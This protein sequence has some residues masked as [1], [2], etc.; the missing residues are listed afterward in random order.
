MQEIFLDIRAG[1]RN[2]SP[3]LMEWIRHGYASAGE[4]RQSG[5]ERLRLHGKSAEE[6]YNLLET[7]ILEESLYEIWHTEGSS[8]RKFLEPDEYRLFQKQVKEAFKKHEA[9]LRDVIREEIKPMLAENYNVNVNGY[10]RFSAAKLKQ[11]LRG[12]LEDVYDRLEEELEQEEF[13]ELLRFFV[14][15]QPSLLDTAHL[16]FCDTGFT[17]TDEWGNDLRK[18]YLDTFLEEEICDVSDNDLVMSILITLLPQNIYVSIEAQTDNSRFLYL[19]QQVF[20]ERLIW[21]KFC[22]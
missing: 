6:L 4:I 11:I 12:V 18:I 16:T 19:L 17:L 21:Q 9:Q 7:V 2:R 14:A 1:T 20:G 13:L 10:L 8:Y 5:Y 22:Y 15:V 3:E